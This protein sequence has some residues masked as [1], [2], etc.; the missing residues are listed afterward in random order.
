MNQIQWALPTGPQLVY[1][2]IEHRLLRCHEALEI[3]WSVISMILPQVRRNLSW[4]P[5]R[6]SSTHME[7]ATSPVPRTSPP[8]S[9]YDIL[10]A[11]LRFRLATKQGL[12]GQAEFGLAFRLF[13]E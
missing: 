13:R 12:K 3:D 7:A 1:H 5:I 9:V 10:A 6:C 4:R 2:G 11:Q 8:S